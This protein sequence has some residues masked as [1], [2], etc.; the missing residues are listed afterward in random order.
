[1]CDPVSLGIGLVGG[2]V[3]SKVLAPKSSAPA[4]APAADP[5]AERAAAEAEAQQRANHQLAEDNKRRRGQQSLIAKGAPQPKLYDETT[6][7][8]VSPIGGASSR[9]TTAGNTRA[10]LISLGAA[11]AATAPRGGS[12]GGGGGGTRYNQAQY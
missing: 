7:D 6:G 3:A 2:M 8:G 12:T 4:A 5:A 9:P 10:S 1:M 11:P